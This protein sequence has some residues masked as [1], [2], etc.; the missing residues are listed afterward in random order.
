MQLDLVAIDQ[1]AHGEL[2]HLFGDATHQHD[3]LEQFL[4]L[5]VEVSCMAI[6]TSQ[7]NRPVM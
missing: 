1:H 7:P 5:F 4:K 3:V 2:D 6:V